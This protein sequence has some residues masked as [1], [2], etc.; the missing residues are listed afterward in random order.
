MYYNLWLDVEQKV[1]IASVNLQ[2]D[3]LV[4]LQHFVNVLSGFDWLSV[5]LHY[6]ITLLNPSSETKRKETIVRPGS[7]ESSVQ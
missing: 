4:T 6:N 2:Q 5:K 1:N 7:R 3:G